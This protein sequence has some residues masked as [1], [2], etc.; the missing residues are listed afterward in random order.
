MRMPARNGCSMH[1]NEADADRFVRILLMIPPTRSGAVRFVGTPG[2]KG[3]ISG[4]ER[5][6][7]PAWPGV[8]GLCGKERAGNSRMTV[9]RKELIL[10]GGR[11][12]PV[13]LDFSAVDADVF[14]QLTLGGV[15]SVAQGYVEVF[16]RLF[17]VVITAHHD[18]LVRN[19]EINPDMVEI[20]L[21]LMTVLGFDCDLAADDMVAELFQLRYFLANLGFDG[22]GVRKAP[23]RNL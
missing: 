4:M 20:T 6:Y 8:L 13:V 7:L 18:V 22:I 5:K 3:P 9:Y 16:V 21:M 1:H 11:R 19:G 15:E 10:Q 17:V 23:E 2:S 12:S 14:F